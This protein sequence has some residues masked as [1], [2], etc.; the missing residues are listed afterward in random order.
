MTPFQRQK[1]FTAEC[2]ED[3]EHLVL[4]GELGALCGE[5]LLTVLFRLLLATND[6]I[7]WRTEVAF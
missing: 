1:P 4:L 7:A 2:A 3:A 5:K 6:A